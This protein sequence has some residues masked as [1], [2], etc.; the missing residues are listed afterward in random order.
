MSVSLRNAF[1]V[2]KNVTR[3]LFGVQLQRIELSARGD[4]AS[5]T[6]VL[7]FG[8]IGQ[9]DFSRFAPWVT[10]SDGILTPSG[11]GYDAYWSGIP[12]WLSDGMDQG[13]FTKSQE[14]V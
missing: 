6:L 9:Y 8:P 3:T 14:G 4:G 12:D 10:A 13:N 5:V 11:R 2:A 7:S 1:D